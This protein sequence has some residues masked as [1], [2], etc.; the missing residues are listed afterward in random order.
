MIGL[1]H[2]TPCGQAYFVSPAHRGRADEH[3]SVWLIE[4]VEEIACFDNAYTRLWYAGLKGWG[5]DSQGLNQLRVIGTNIRRD[6]LKIAKFTHDSGQWHG[7]P[8]DVNRKPQD[9]PLP[10]VL[11]R[12]VNDGVI[13]KP[14]MARIQGGRL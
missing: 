5:I 3:K 12:W 14:F 4:P 2:N 9:R 7:Y 8:A 13:S 11:S 1:T 6:S 10:E